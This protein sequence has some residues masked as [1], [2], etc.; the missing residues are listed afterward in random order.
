MTETRVVTN[1]SAPALHPVVGGPVAASAA[2]CADYA[3]FAERVTASTLITD[4]W[5]D[6]APRFS[7]HPQVLTLSAASALGRA[8]ED[9]AHAY[10]EGVC[11][12]LR[13]PG[14]LDTFFGLTPVQKQMVD[15]GG[16]LWHGLA[17]ADLFRSRGGLVTSELNCDT[18][19]GQPEAVVTSA[20][21]A[22]GEAGLHDPNAR[23][24]RALID[25]VGAISAAAAPARNGLAVG[26]VYPTEFTE[27][28]A[29]VRWL[30]GLFEAEGH[31][32]VYGAPFNLES[33]PDGGVALFGEEVSVLYRHYKTDYWSERESAFLD[34]AIEDREPLTRELDVLARASALHRVACINPFSSVLAQN[35]RMMAFFWEHLTALSP[36]AQATVRRMVPPTFRLEHQDAAK[37]LAEREKWVLKSDYGA[38]GDEVIVGA[39]V[40]HELFRETLKQARPKRWIVQRYFDVTPE[41][42]GALVNY[43]VYL[44]GGV[45]SGLYLR[46]QRGP[47]D[48]HA[49]SVPVVLQ[50]DG[51]PE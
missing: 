9:L 13:Q 48:E 14:L 40:S 27:D 36:R 49:L 39:A 50:A 21:F 20:M 22:N 15:L 2:V 47:T 44:C 6:G 11:A 10:H 51:E 33:T 12:V 37:L 23:L 30:A 18:P 7:P 46:S 38:E 45:A 3:A 16:S 28:L 17:R 19:T 31:R 26:I 4:P 43:G 34:E 1:D 32:V 25:V 41:P 24:G 29:L 42:D 5:L 8:A 35:K